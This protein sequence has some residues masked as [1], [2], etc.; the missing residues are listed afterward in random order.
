VERSAPRV[1][2]D[3][4]ELQPGAVVALDERLGHYLRAVLRLSEGDALTVLDGAGRAFAATL[5]SGALQIGAPADA[6]T[7]DL[8]AEA[9]CRVEILQALPKG[10]K[11]GEIIRRATELGAWRI[12]P[13]LTARTIATAGSAQKLERWRRIAREAARQS[14]RLHVPEVEAPRPLAEAMRGARGA[15]R[16][17][18]HEAE[19][20]LRLRDLLA[21]A[22]PPPAGAPRSV[23]IAVGPEGGFTAAEVAEAG[24]CGFVAAGLGPRVMRTETVA[25]AVCAVLQHVWGDL[26]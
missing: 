4:A 1:V 11:L 25:L 8:A 26:G 17:L 10:D 21:A 2:V 22:P 14:R 12:V 5:G 23:T 24:A 19:R 6:A 7:A 9:P 20:A 18:L 16:V 15:L 13:A 3:A